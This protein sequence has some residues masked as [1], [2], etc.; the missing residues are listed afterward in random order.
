MVAQQGMP[1][2][3]QKRAAYKR[4]IE[5][6]TRQAVVTKETAR[7]S[8]IK[9]GIYTAEGKLA[10]EFGGEERAKPARAA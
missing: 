6:H 10:P 2:T 1:M 3:D 7:E 4:L 8:L 9:E 5:R